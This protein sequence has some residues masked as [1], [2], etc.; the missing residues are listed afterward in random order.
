[1]RKPLSMRDLRR[2][3]PPERASAKKTFLRNG[4]DLGRDGQNRQRKDQDQEWR[5]AKGS[6]GGGLEIGD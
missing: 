4:L 2:S 6:R 5:G 1:M 3:E